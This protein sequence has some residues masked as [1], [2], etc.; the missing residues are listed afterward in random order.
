MAQPSR[1][2]SVASVSSYCRLCS[3]VCGVKIELDEQGRLK[4]VSGDKSH[5][6]TLGYACSKGLA[7]P[8]THNH[9]D[10]LLQS[11]KRQ[12]DGSFAPIPLEQALDEIAERVQAL[13]ESHGASSIAAYRGTASYLNALGLVM[14][15][16]WLRA[17]G[18]SSMFSTMT[19]D[20][21][22]K[23]VTVER[24]GRWHAGRHP[25]ET[26]EIGLIFGANPLVSIQGGLGITTLN[27]SK[28]LAE[29]RARG[30]KLIVV[31]P[32]RTELARHA[33]L[34]LQ[35]YPG[36][37]VA[38][39][40]GLLHVV[41][42]EGWHDAAFCERWVN[43]LDGL[44]QA[45]AAYTP[46]YVA[47]Q[48]GIEAADLVQAA[49]MFAHDARRGAASSGTGP[50]M[51]QHSNLAE[52]LIECLNVV[53]G[54]YQRAGDPVANPGVLSKPSAIYAEVRPPKRGWESGL[55]SRVRGLG[56]LMGEKMTGALADEILQPG[57]EQIK[58]LFVVG[59]NPASALP[60]QVRAIEALSA[61]E[62]LVVIEPFMSTTARLAHYILAPKLQYER[63][64]LPTL[65]DP[66][67]YPEPFGQYTPAVATAPEGVVDEWYPFWAL[68]QRMQKP[69]RLRGVSLDRETAPSSDELLDIL[70]RDAR[71]PLADIRQHSAGKRYDLAPETV[72]PAR[73]GATGRFAV[74]PPD[75]AEELKIV[76]QQA[77]GHGA[78]PGRN[79][80]YTHLL[81]VRR[82]RAVLNTALHNLPSVRKRHPF[83]TLA[84]HP[85]D[86][87][88]SGLKDGQKIMVVGEHGRIPAVLE[89][90]ADQK[91]G[92]LAMSHGWGGLPA[93]GQDYEEVGANTGLLVSDSVDID[94]I[95]AMAR[96]TG[97]PVRL[98]RA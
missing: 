73:E 18:S 90:D 47:G 43:N 81:A 75:V 45:V 2:D 19:I 77:G 54:R 85:D 12:P 24:L 44:R 48:A 56:M 89:S 79:G 30:F 92:V 61:L 41:L 10:R 60:N 87:D 57:P 66:G 39:A 6:M 31:D 98:E 29:A 83:N 34:H 38:V 86:L 35:I 21:S 58:T 32:R 14:P 82:L 59:G 70:V 1:L 94:P 46:D 17:I 25:F 72:Q 8:E 23:W 13:I 93:D 55:R 7:A 40:A 9:L 5:A 84:I 11:L 52:H 96:M 37:D 68:G 4:S 76:R 69:L 27:P 91:P 42:R 71:I 80:P 22:A 50:D 53:C 74:L 3:G 49:K 28:R 51:G 36:E 26:A 15:Q 65:A 16:L 20:Q 97:L 95:N 63:P 64:D 62:L 78:Y 88:S 67:Y 33:A